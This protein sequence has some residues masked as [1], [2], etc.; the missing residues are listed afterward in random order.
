MAVV[1]AASALDGSIGWLVGNGGGMSCAAGYLPESTARAWFAPPQAFVASATG[2]VGTARPVAGGYLVSGRWPFASGIHHATRVMGLCTTRSE[3]PSQLDHLVC[4]Y[5]DPKDVEII[6]N[7]HVSGLRGTG[8]CDFKAEE[9]FVSSDCAHGFINLQPTQPGGVYR[10][11]PSSAFAMTVA[12]VPL[13]ISWAALLE[14]IDLATAR[15]RGGQSQSLRETE[16]VQSEVGRA[17]AIYSA[18]HALLSSAIIELGDATDA[19]GARLIEARARFRVAC[20]HVAE[21]AVKV[22][23]MLAAMAGAISI[24]EPAASS[25]ASATFT[26]LSSTWRCRPPVTRLPDASGSA[27]NR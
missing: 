3:G 25:A 14:F 17:E 8:S 21:S 18:A 4:C 24:F 22:V 6:D 7:W 27:W 2:A 12:V 15:C 20:A 23:D 5:L 9:I 10:L 1:E 13:G 19:G 26:P 16:S 11:P